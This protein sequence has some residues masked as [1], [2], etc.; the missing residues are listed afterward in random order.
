MTGG[1][2]LVGV[3][4]LMGLGSQK[5]GLMGRLFRYTIWLIAAG[6]VAALL[7][8]QARSDDWPQFRGPGGSGVAAAHS[9]PLEWGKDKNIAWKIKLPGYGWSSPVVW[10]DK[11]FVTTAVSDKQKK[12]GFGGFPGFGGGFPGGPG[13]PV[14][15]G[16]FPGGKGGRVPGGFGGPLQPG[17]L[18]PSFLQDRLQLT[19]EQKK[20]LEALQKEVDARLGQ[21]LTAE[22]QKQLK[23]KR[24]GFGMMSSRP[25][26][27]VYKWEVY[28]LNAADGKVLWKQTAAQGKPKVG[29]NPAN[30]YAT[31]T[32]VTDGK[33]VYAYFGTAGVVVC[34]DLAGKPLWKKELGTYQ[35]MFGHGTASSPVLEGSRL[36]I[37]CDN[38]EKSFLVALDAATG[39]ELW[40]VDRSERTSWSTPIVWKNRLRTEIVCLGSPRV[41]SYDPATGKQLWELGGL[42]GQPKASP[43]AGPDMLYVGIDATMGGFFGGGRPGVSGPA[44]PRRGGRPLYAIKAG[45]SGD[46]T[47]AEGAKSNAGVAWYL[48]Q[49]APGTATPLLV[50]DCLYVVSD[51]GGLLHCYDAKTGK[52]IYKERLPGA[53]GFT[54]SPWAAAGKLFFLDDGGTTFVVQAGRRF[55]LLAR[56]S[57]DEM[58]WSSPAVADGA[59]FLRGVDHLYCI[60]E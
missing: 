33:R 7:P 30:T 50:D 22:Q 48:S 4:I 35:V 32:P 38:E 46:I 24:G 29:I 1:N 2:R 5:G 26:D 27:S 3:T 10:G 44:S 21:I 57:L 43:V 28:C 36:F 19:D 59:F 18:I 53:G 42:G 16:G 41:R 34:Y 49:A 51:R 6:L 56:N 47:L 40:R 20:Q 37:Q 23:G 25:P 9:V 54:A 45:A 60:K 15:K 58:C 8:A 52:Q 17:Q 12:P 55:K 14:G 11:V 31:E 39:K 13:A